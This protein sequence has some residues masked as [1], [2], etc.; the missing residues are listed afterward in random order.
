MIKLFLEM[1]EDAQAAIEQLTD[2]IATQGF[3]TSTGK[4]AQSTGC[5]GG[6]TTLNPKR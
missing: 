2:S 6:L 4:V 1:M 3:D 5:S